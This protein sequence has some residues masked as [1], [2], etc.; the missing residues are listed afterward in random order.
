M[1]TITIQ[2][3][4][5]ATIK[6]V[7]DCWT[8]EKHIIHWNFASD[9]WCCPSAKNELRENGKFNYRM[10]AKDESFGFDFEGT[11]L[12]IIPTESIEYELDDQRKVKI[13]FIEKE[14]Q[15]EI[16]EVF[17]AENENPIEMQ[18]QGWQLILNNFKKYAESIL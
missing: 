3:L 10:A 9:E 16:I 5:S 11:Y 6:H 7:W 1:N 4:V 8:N 2:T 14:N 15:V 12:K 18:Q 17:E 13:S